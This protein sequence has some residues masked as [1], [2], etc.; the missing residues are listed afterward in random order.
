MINIDMNKVDI[1]DLAKDLL[2][3]VKH[4]TKDDF[5]KEVITMLINNGIRRHDENNGF[6]I[7]SSIKRTGP[8]NVD[9]NAYIEV[10][11]CNLYNAPQEKFML[12]YINNLY[13][14]DLDIDSYS[15]MCVFSIL[16]EIGHALDYANKL[17][18]NYNV[19]EYMDNNRTA[20]ANLNIET[21]KRLA[22]C[23][24]NKEKQQVFYDDWR[25]YRELETEYQ[26]D[27]WASL[28][29]KEYEGALNFELNMIDIFEY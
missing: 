4:N 21:E 11:Y 26:A 12:K 7:C 13:D 23:T 20:L 28:F 10:P 5:E 2:E 17:R 9:F 27:K 15:D 19:S 25:S 18:Y 29:I 22:Q 6:R 1:I 24:N 3:L 14:L 16:H 8:Q